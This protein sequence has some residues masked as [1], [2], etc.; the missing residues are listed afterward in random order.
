MNQTVTGTIHGNTIV[1]DAPPG[2]ADGQ[3]VEVVIRAVTAPAKWGEGIL[4][5]A[6]GWTAYPEMDAIMDKIHAERKLER[7]T[8]SP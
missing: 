1:L 7:R 8:P 6:G 5:S 2:V 4:N 3:A